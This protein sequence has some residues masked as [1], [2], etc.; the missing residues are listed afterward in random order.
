FAGGQT[1]VN[2]R[3][4]A[5]G[6][7]TAR[8]WA[9]QMLADKSVPKDQMTSF[10]IF[11]GVPS[12]AT[13]LLAVPKEEMRAF[14]RRE[15]EQARLADAAKRA[16]ATGFPGGQGAPSQ[17]WSSSGGGDP[18]IRVS[19]PGAVRAQAI[20]PDGR[21]ISLAPSPGNPDLWTGNYEISAS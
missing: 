12:T 17:N 15:M 8:L 4:L 6:S 11:F 16:P 3:M 1:T 9:Q 13:A 14:L 21:R 20:L 5:R 19:L 7:D 2:P 18:E 10:S